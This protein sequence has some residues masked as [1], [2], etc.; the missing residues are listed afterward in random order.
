MTDQITTDAADSE[1]K[2][3]LVTFRVNDILLGISIDCVQEINRLL[4]VTAVPG[5]S[6][7]IHGV[8]NLRGEVVTVIDAHQLFGV[9]SQTNPEN[10]RNLVLRVDGEQIGIL[11]DEIADILTIRQCDLSPRPSNLRSVDRR[12]IDSVF[13]TSGSIVVVLDAS[14]LVNAIDQSDKAEP[15]LA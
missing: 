3:Q 10:Q 12:F 8:V 11:V 1:S 9:R 14:S 6:R 13:L 2:I 5:A 7:L 15:V 4:D